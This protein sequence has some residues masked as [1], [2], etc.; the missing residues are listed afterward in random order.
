VLRGVAPGT[1]RWEQF[2]TPKELESALKAAGMTDIKPQGLV[3]SPLRGEWTLS[4]DCDVNYF[5][6]AGKA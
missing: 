1:H 4:R 6:T 5:V 3:F 2:V